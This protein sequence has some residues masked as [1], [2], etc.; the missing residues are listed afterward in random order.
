VRNGLEDVSISMSIIFNT[1][2]SMAHIRA[3]LLNHRLRRVLQPLG[4]APG[5]VGQ[6][7]V[8]DGLKATIWSAGAALAQLK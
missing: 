4:L 8:R 7:P 5:P 3:T 2:Q 6:R 1:N